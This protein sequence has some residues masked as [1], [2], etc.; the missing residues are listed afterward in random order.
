MPLAPAPLRR[1][2]A[3]SLAALAAAGAVAACSDSTGPR[4][5]LEGSWVAAGSEALVPTFATITLTLDQEG[6]RVTG[7]GS[8]TYPPGFP[9]ALA[10]QGVVEAGIVTLTFTS[11]AL[12]EPMT[13]RAVLFDG[14]R[15]FTGPLTLGQSS[16]T[17]EFVRF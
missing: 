14:G 2:L 15:K 1:R 4:L 11:P 13:I 8:M 7:T 12:P 6:D 10:A 17:R 5:P 16:E 9:S 3:R